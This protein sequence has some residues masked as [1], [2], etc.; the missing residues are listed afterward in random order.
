MSNYFCE[1]TKLSVNIV[2]YIPNS[3]IGCNSNCHYL[4]ETLT[5]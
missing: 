3:I 2:Q 1:Y 4:K 5:N